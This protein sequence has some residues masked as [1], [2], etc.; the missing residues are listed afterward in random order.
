MNAWLFSPEMVVKWAPVEVNGLIPAIDPDD[1]RNR[2]CFDHH[3][4]KPGCKCWC[5]MVFT[6]PNVWNRPTG[7]SENRFNQSWYARSVCGSHSIL[8][9]QGWYHRLS[10]QKSPGNHWV[11]YWLPYEKPVS[12]T[13]WP[14]DSGVVCSFFWFSRKRKEAPFPQWF[15]VAGHPAGSAFELAFVSNTPAVK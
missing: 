12:E 6:T 3:G 1:L 11:A 2:L 5:S 14:S 13:W 7:Y 15:R 4:C 8:E 9:L 10:F